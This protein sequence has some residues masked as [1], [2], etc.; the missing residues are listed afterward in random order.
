MINVRQSCERYSEPKTQRTF[1]NLEPSH[2]LRRSFNS[3]KLSRQYPVLATFHRATD[4]ALLGLLLTVIVMSTVALHAQ[5]LWNVSFS[6]LETSR[7][8]IQKLRESTA[9]LESHFLTS[10]SLS[11][12]MVEPANPKDHLLYLDKPI[13][14]RHSVNYRIKDISFLE[15]IVY[16]PAGYGY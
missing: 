11:K 1:Y 6:R 13:T 15:K 14:G 2:L 7:L 4:G 9:M 10:K 16:F 8:L 12:F 5:H 3:K